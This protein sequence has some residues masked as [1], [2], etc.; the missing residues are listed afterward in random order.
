MT[1]TYGRK[2]NH[3]TPGESCKDSHIRPK[4][5]V[6]KPYIAGKRLTYRRET[7]KKSGKKAICR[8]EKAKKAR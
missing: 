6:R 2:A 1:V 7:A 5:Q 4:S 3:I 8:R